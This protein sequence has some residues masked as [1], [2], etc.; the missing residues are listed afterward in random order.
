M[1]MAAEPGLLSRYE[2]RWSRPHPVSGQR[3]K[4]ASNTHSDTTAC[5]TAEPST[6]KRSGLATRVANCGPIP[7]A[8]CVGCGSWRQ[9]T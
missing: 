5:V 3:P 7:V 2:V 4:L 1:L 6:V 9:V 8:I